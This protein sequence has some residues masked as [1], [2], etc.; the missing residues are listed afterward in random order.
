MRIA[1][2]T[3]LYNEELILP[4]FLRHYQY[5]NEIRVLY[6]TDSTDG[7]LNILKNTPNVTIDN[8]HIEDGLDDIDK[9]NLLNNALRDIK[10]DW[11][12]VL[13]SDEFIF[14]P[15]E[16]PRDFLKRQDYDVVRAAMFQVYRHRTDKDLD[17]SSPPVPQRIHGD[18]DVFSN[19]GKPNRDRNNL[20][21]KPIVVKNSAGI[22]LEPGGHAVL[23]NARISPEFY[24]GAHWQMA[25]PLIAIDRRLKNQAR[26]SK[27][28]K[29][30][31]MGWQHVNVTRE[32]IVEECDRHLDEPIIQELIPVDR[33]NP[34]EI[35]A[36]CNKAF[37]QEA[38]I[39][40]L[41]NS[42]QDRDNQ[43]MR[44]TDSVTWQIAGK[45]HSIANKVLPP[46]IRR[47]LLTRLKKR[48]LTQFGRKGARSGSI[49]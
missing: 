48:N 2:L 49:S 42:I 5:L 11:V 33:K 21:V 37:I 27:R 41:K 3:M 8:V 4:Y 24:L 35:I 30:L 22:R 28:N 32:W 44:I 45:L 15:N 19:V 40:E 43:L 20:Y 26:L 1:A 39:V 7:T 31:G 47:L 25:D 18:P 23:G 10:A 12:Y 17:P 16:S 46:Q 13:D 6:E 9:V 14:P 29:T 34:A 38:L 36:L